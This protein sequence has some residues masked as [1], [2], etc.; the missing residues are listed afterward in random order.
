MHHEPAIDHSLQIALAH[1]R[2]RGQTRTRRP[3]GFD[4]GRRLR[5]CVAHDQLRTGLSRVSGLLAVRHCRV[6]RCLRRRLTPS[7]LP[8]LLGFDPFRQQQPNFHD[9]CAARARSGHGPRAVPSVR[10]TGAPSWLGLLPAAVAFFGGTG[11]VLE[12]SLLA[13]PL[14]AFL[15]VVGVYFA[16]RAMRESALRW[17]LLA[18]A[19]IGMA[20]LDQD[21]RGVKCDSN[22]A[23][24]VVCKP[25]RHPATPEPRRRNLTRRSRVHRRLCKKSVCCDRL[26]GCHAPGCVE[27]VWASG[28][29]RRLLDV[30]ATSRHRLSVSQSAAGTSR[31][32]KRL[33]VLPELAGR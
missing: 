13:D 20:F 3:G 10:R 8:D 22:T 19:A 1:A 14:F 11:L 9:R 31:S 4:D 28:D 27:S 23:A 6:A 12:H 7:R 30:H 17:S 16:V 26:P 21:G 5:P 2:S 33:S 15:Q 18:G 25:W 24:A 32:A 29:V